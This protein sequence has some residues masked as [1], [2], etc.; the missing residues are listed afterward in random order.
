MSRSLDQWI[1]YIQT[2]HP[3]TID[4][5]LD[6]VAQVWD[7]FKPAELPP[8]IAVAGTNG[9]GSSVSMLESIYRYAGYRTA[10]FTSPHLVRFNERLCLDNIPVDDDR[11]LASFARIEALR[12]DVSLTFFEFN[13]LLALDIF[14]AEK[15]GVILLE[16][17]L[18]GRLDAVNIVDNNLA[19]ITAIDI[20]HTAWLG[21][22]REQIGAEKAGIIKAGGLAVLADPEA[23][24]SMVDIAK[25]RQAVLVQ[26]G[27]D[28]QL[29]A[30]PQEKCCFSSE[31]AGLA[32]FDGFEFEPA[33]QHVYMNSGGVLAAIAM[34]NSRLPITR[35]QLRTGL[36]RQKLSGRLQLIKGEPSIL[37]DVS[38]NEASVLSM[39]EYIDSL[40][41]EGRIHAVFGALV[42]KNYG[43]AYDALKARID[44]WYLC[45][46]EGDRG[47]SAAALGE[48]LFAQESNFGNGLN[49]GFY[50][51][52]QKAF[53]QAKQKADA[54][55]LIVI[56][57]S[58]HLVGA[59]IPTLTS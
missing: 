25:S 44:A 4:L 2:L 20:D 51:S 19:L 39:L 50:P 26:A 53:V 30:G 48:K 14:C 47:Q 16:V 37:L 7:R 1:E 42:D 10:A 56:F 12:G 34:M 43:S 32:M 27:I 8:V 17:G 46:L 23:P 21:S 58:F 28:Y 29:E 54:R 57:G 15:P 11:L 40:A 59:I 49:A 22:S 35:A 18:G 5:S 31:Q 13:T 24:R 33:L 9:K 6:R 41:I 36:A 38:H 45:D 55:D 52:P 3:R